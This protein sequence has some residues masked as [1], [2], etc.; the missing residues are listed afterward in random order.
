MDKRQLQ[1]RRMREA[2]AEQ[3]HDD[4]LA[5]VCRYH[6]VPVM[7]HEV[8]RFLA[9]M[10]P[11]ARVLDIGGC[12]GWHWRRLGSQRRDV[13]VVIADF[14]RGNLVHA[15]KL[16]GPLAGSQVLLATAD[17]TD[18]PFADA[19]FDG[20]WTVQTFQHIP[21]FERAAVEAHRVL[22]KGGL[23]SSYSAHRT[24]LYQLAYRLIGRRLHMDG[25]GSDGLYLIRANNG[26]RSII[27]KVFGARVTDR[28]TESL[29]HPDLRMI[30]AGREGS[31]LGRIDAAL[32]DF[33]WLG[34]WIGRQRS[35][36]STKR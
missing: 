13:T 3:P 22:V 15:R 26:Q 14:V 8:E 4:L 11:N 17:A 23:F 27:E 32:S 21:D 24:P 19:T 30:R 7:D 28:Y 31:L 12:W 18:L 20:V 6:S 16:L 2:V 5:E 9:R 33:S 1:E 10:P 29:F 35:F 25:L 34:R 36:S